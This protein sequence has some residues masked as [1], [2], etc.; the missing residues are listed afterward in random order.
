VLAAISTLL[1]VLA[2]TACVALVW[3]QP[4]E[5]ERSAQ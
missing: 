4:A 5:N 2:F 3:W 1:T